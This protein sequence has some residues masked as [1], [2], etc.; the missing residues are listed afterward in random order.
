MYY[1]LPLLDHYNYG[2]EGAE[3]ALDYWSASCQLA[4]T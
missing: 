2:T 1:V 4:S 3:L